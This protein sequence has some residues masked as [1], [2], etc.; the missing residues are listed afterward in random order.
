MISVRDRLMRALLNRKKATR[1]TPKADITKNLQAS[2]V[3]KDLKA[4]IITEA[5]DLITTI[6]AAAE[7]FVDAGVNSVMAVMI[8]VR[9]NHSA[10]RNMMIMAAI[11]SVIICAVNIKSKRSSS[12]G[13]SCW[14]RYRRKSAAIKA[15]PF[16]HIC[17][18]LVV[19]AY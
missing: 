3:K 9:S 8:P 12:A 19:I 2:H 5:A 14:C 17:P 10:A 15:P 13:K 7:S 1:K 6:D 11:A 16:Q 18:C 4:A